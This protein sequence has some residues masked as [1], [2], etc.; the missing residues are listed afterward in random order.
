MQIVFSEELDKI[1][2][3]ARDEAMRTGSMAILPDHLALGL[4]RHSAN[5]ACEALD[6]LGVDREEMKHFI[7]SQM[8]RKDSI[9][10]SDI[11]RVEFSRS[12]RDVLNMSI[13]EASAAGRDKADA[14]HLLMA[15]ARYAESIGSS[16]LHGAGA[17]RDS[18]AGALK[19][20]SE[21]KEAERKD[22]FRRA[23]SDKFFELYQKTDKIYS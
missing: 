1:L 3:Y 10:Y 11:D 17:D 15:L 21:L 18:I 20:V 2:A 22:Q 8:Y 9:S 14:G 4:L 5:S 23:V 19:T 7:E 12:S 6:R 13:L 16:Y